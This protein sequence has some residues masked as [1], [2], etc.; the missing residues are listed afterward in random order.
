MSIACSLTLATLA[1]V[2]ADAETFALPPAGE[3]VVGKPQIIITREKDTLLDIARSYDLGYD[4][5]VKANPGVDPWLPKPGTRILLPTQF[6]LPEGKRQGIVLNIAEMRLYFFPKA[7]AG[8]T[9]VVV[10]HPVGIGREGWSTPLGETK[11]ASKRANPKWY[12]PQS[13]QKEH[14]EKGDPLPRV[15]PAGPDNPLGNYAMPLGIPGYLIHG[16]N[17]PFGIGR[18][19]SHGC[20]QLYPEDIEGLFKDIPVGT[21]VRIINHPYKAGWLGDKIYLET[22]QPLEEDAKKGVNLTPMVNIILDAAKD[23]KVV[24]WDK[25]TEVAS[26]HIGIPMTVSVNTPSIDEELLALNQLEPSPN[27][28]KRDDAHEPSLAEVTGKWFIKV[29]GLDNQE[30]AYRL[31]AMLRHL[32]PPI[33]AM[34]T[35]DGGAYQVLSGP[36]SNRAEALKASR[37]INT[38]LEV[39]AQV[40]APLGGNQK[41]G[42]SIVKD[43]K[44]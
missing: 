32:G 37:R 17:K 31:A 25:A 2:P 42:Q 23:R 8:Q 43:R 24:N 4:E 28:A 15:V 36:Y 18:R 21:P 33:P 5:I 7:K 19:I 40:M 27:L 12:V 34:A 38:N 1:A 30:N 29:G 44:G 3:D 9:P 10:T 20:I 11:V 39:T 26:R 14:A 16:T 41:T 35:Q 22:H 6:I 13:I